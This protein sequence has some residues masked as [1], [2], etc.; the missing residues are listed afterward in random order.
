LTLVLTGKDKRKVLEQA[1]KQGAS[2]STP[3]GRVLAEA[4]HAVDIHWCP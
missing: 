2:S 3:I 4:D 1:I